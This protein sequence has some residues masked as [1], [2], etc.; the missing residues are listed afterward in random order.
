MCKYLVMSSSFILFPSYNKL[1]DTKATSQK[2]VSTWIH[3]WII[4]SPKIT[5]PQESSLSLVLGFSQHFLPF[6]YSH[7]SEVRHWYRAMTSSVRRFIQNVLD[8]AEVRDQ[9]RKK[10]FYNE[11]GRKF[12]LWGAGFCACGY[13]LTKKVYPKSQYPRELCPSW[14]KKFSI[15]DRKWCRGWGGE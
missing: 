8:G 6:S 4:H 3:L 10:S 12:S 1:P 5:M 14:M 9:A 15:T 7:I 11:F 13:V 2:F